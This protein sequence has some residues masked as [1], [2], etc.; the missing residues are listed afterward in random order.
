MS[1]EERKIQLG[2][3]I[4]QDKNKKL[5][6]R[7]RIRKQC[8]K[9]NIEIT[10]IDIHKELDKQG[11]FDVLVHKIV[12]FTKDGLSNMES[13]QLI[14][15]T[16][17]YCQ[18]KPD[19]AVIDNIKIISN[20]TSRSYQYNILNKCSMTVDNIQVYVPKSLEIPAD[21]SVEKLEELVDDAGIQFPVLGKP[22]AS[23]TAKGAHDMTL[24]FSR[25]RI[26]DLP[27]P[28]LLQEFRNHGG[29]IYKVFVMGD[30]I[31]MCER[32]SVKDLNC[33]PSR[34]S[35][36][37]DTRDISK[38]GKVFVPG[39]QE[40]DPNKRVWLSCDE[41]PDLLNIK[42]VKAV[43][44]KLSELTGLKLYGMDILKDKNG[45]YAFVDLNHFPGYTG[46][47]ENDFV[48]NF[49]EMIKNSVKW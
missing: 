4:P 41:K 38:I 17:C 25:K 20:L 37:F 2:I 24:V 45:N 48:Q 43:H 9:E 21:C 14:R 33:D 13:E 34:S 39:L 44:K 22:L 7:E 23:S 36:V 47:K 1:S 28:C 26:R 15:K 27:L 18:S 16:E 6:L 3:M 31:N 49:I 35:L 5:K 10:E 40:E 8:D 12:D 30:R 32:P 19:M 46:V 29:V 11:P 42:V